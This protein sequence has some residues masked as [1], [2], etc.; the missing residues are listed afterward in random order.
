MLHVAECSPKEAN[1]L[2][3]VATRPHTPRALG[4]R[5]GR[6]REIRGVETFTGASRKAALCTAAQMGIDLRSRYRD[7]SFHLSREGT[8][9]SEHFYTKC[10]FS[11]ENSRTLMEVARFAFFG[12]A[13]TGHGYRSR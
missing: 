10:A 3:N 1:T 7:E 9:L 5:N 12:R 8:F 13:P 2:A 11:Y 6:A 4:H